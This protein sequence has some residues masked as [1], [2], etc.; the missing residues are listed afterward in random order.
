MS[1][2]KTLFLAGI[3]VLTTLY[4][5]KVSIPRRESEARVQR[6][7]RSLQEGDLASVEVVGAASG[8]SRFTLEQRRPP[9]ASPQ[10]AGDAQTSFWEISQLKGAPV[11]ASSI[12]EL[13][14]GILNLQ[15]S[16]PIDAKAQSQDFSTYGLDKP[17]LTLVIKQHTGESTEVAFGKENAFLGQRY[18]KVGG[19][20]GIYLADQSAVTA[21]NKTVDD[22]RSKNPLDMN[23]EDVR[24]LRIVSSRGSITVTQPVVGEW[25]ILEPKELAAS[26]ELMEAVIQSIG[27]LTVSEFLDGQQNDLAKYRLDKPDVRV[28]IM[29]RP[30]S[31]PQKRV[32]S[33]SL[34][35]GGKGSYFVYDGAPSVFKTDSDNVAA[36][37]KG[38]DNLREHRL[39]KLASSDIASDR[40]SVV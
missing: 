17:F 11:D 26:G 6:V 29:M 18:V 10:G 40:K 16:G 9:Q 28:E 7:F 39:L 33:V 1:P 14:E 12:K 8:V 5:Y 23:Q 15:V 38:V 22:V 36:L 31:E 37:A 13:S 24:E 20:S 3:L 32:V 35:D 30:G 27:S 25:R 2:R 21:L 19:K 4:L 34:R